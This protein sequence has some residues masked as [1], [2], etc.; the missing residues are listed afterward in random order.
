MPMSARVATGRTGPRVGTWAAGERRA[1]QARA[2]PRDLGRSQA[3]PWAG[4]GPW[5]GSCKDSWRLPPPSG[6]G[7]RVG[8]AAIPG[9]QALHPAAARGGAVPP[10]RPPARASSASPCAGPPRGHSFCGGFAPCFLDGPRPGVRRRRWRWW[11]Y[12]D[13]SGEGRA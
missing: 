4:L 1:G 7:A 13:C 6:P 12:S 10:E 11:A 5:G 8:S 9:P 2:G 3:A